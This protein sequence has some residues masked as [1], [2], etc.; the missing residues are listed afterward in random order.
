MAT[1]QE[2]LSK[3][4]A[5]HEQRISKVLFDLEEDIIAQLQRATDGVP[6]TTDLAIQL[7]P[8]LKQ[9]IEQNYLKEGSKIISEYD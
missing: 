5:S 3:L 9:L 1:K 7:R 4:A 2:I 6:L 8:N